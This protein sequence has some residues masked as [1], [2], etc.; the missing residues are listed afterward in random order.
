[1]A[2]WN[3]V[4][5]RWSPGAAAPLGDRSLPDRPERAAARAV[6][7]AT[8]SHRAAPYPWR[9]RLGA[10]VA[11]FLGLVLLAWLLPTVI[12]RTPLMGWILGR[13]VRV[14]GTASLEAA[15]LGW[16]SPV[17]LKGL[18][19]HD[20][21]GQAVLRVDRI[22]T[23]KSLLTLLRNDGD[24]GVIRV[25][26]P[27]LDV[28]FREGETNVEEVFAPY[29]E[30]PGDGPLEL[31]VSL[32]IEGLQV[33]LREAASDRRWGLEDGAVRIEL[34]GAESPLRMAAVAALTSGRRTGHLHAE[35]LV[36]Q[37]ATGTGSQ[38]RLA[39]LPGA[40]HGPA[41][42]GDS[43]Q[44][45]VTVRIEGLD[46]SLVEP[47]LRRLA[48]TAGENGP[49]LRELAG[50]AGGE[51]TCRWS[52]G[53]M[54]AL[55]FTGRV[56]A[57]QLTAQ[58]G[59]LGEDRLRLAAIEGR[60][61]AAFDGRSWQV[62]EAAFQSDLGRLDISGV[63]TLPGGSG[64]EALAALLEQP[65]SVEGEVDL[66]R[67]AAA[68]PR[69]LQ[70]R[71]GTDV[72]AGKVRLAVAGGPRTGE[73]FLWQGRLETTH[74]AAVRGGRPIVWEEPISMRFEARR[75]DDGWQIDEARCRADFLSVLAAGT[76]ESAA[77]EVEFDL[78]V[79][80]ERLAGFVDLDR[81]RL[82]G[83][84]RGAVQWQR[85]PSGSFRG[86]ADFSVSDLVLGWGTRTL[87]DEEQVALS[88]Q[89]GGWT[90]RRQWHVS[91]GSR[92]EARVGRDHL[93][94]ELAHP[95]A[96]V[97]ATGRW[98]LVVAATGSLASWQRR[99]EGWLPMEGVQ[100]AGVCR[101]DAEGTVS[102]AGV[103]LSRGR[104]RIDQLAVSAPGW[105]LAEPG[106]EIALRGWWDRSGG[107]VEVSEAE[108]TAAAIALRG[109]NLAWSGDAAEAVPSGQINYQADLEQLSRWLVTEEPLPV[110]L[111]GRLSGTGSL[112]PQPAG[113]RGVALAT[114]H[115]LRLTAAAGG[116]A[117]HE[118]QV[119]LA[120]RGTYQAAERTLVLEQATLTGAAL[121]ADAGGTATAGSDHEV[122]RLDLAGSLQYDLE[123]FGPLLRSYLG[124]GVQVAGAG[125]RP[126]TFRGPLDPL[127]A[128]A[129]AGIVWQR[130]HLYGVQ[131]GSGELSA[132]LAGGVLRL[133]PLDVEVSE[134]RLK[135]APE[136]RLA[137]GPTALV[138]APGPLLEQVRVN[139]RMCAHFLQYV[140]PVLA[141]VTAAE[142]RFSV[143]LDEC[144][145]PLAAPAEA[146]VGGRL[147]VHQI[148]VAA[149][150]LLYELA[151]LLGVE[152]RARLASN[153]VV[154]F[155]MVDRRV[156]HEAVALDLGGLTVQTQ[157]SVG[158]DG[159]LSLLAEVPVPPQWLNEPQIRAAVGS[160]TLRVPIGG[161]LER[162][163]LDRRMLDQ[164]SQQMVRE[165]T[166]NVIE[167]NLN[168]QL[169]RLWRQ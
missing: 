5:P 60:L 134:G 62:A 91:A 165:T 71:E 136:I 84:G 13:G 65:L 34:A 14:E 41:E 127:S 105:A 149:G 6:R 104:A 115:D 52:A 75:T 44:S 89:V 93:R 33:R 12:A 156:Y 27:E 74:L 61:D 159:T 50:T 123:R 8:P 131:V 108:L 17:K 7:P 137:G 28:V 57:E 22:E 83:K 143:T 19:I 110:K 167:E 144:H 129:D 87:A 106:V 154:R 69:L 2:W 40:P 133:R 124:E 9:R 152:A 125:S 88:A 64:A 102:A 68:V 56:A 114:I 161:T 58:G 119:R 99:L 142:G 146:R 24:L 35:A 81:G 11:V 158:L 3:R 164:L 53:P 148:D 163:Q 48:A 101:L 42:S 169:E 168:R 4:R 117:Y 77:A 23:E 155:R 111:S 112:D 79:L 109:E 92:A 51:V 37:G 30:A 66:A 39:S 162:P 153:S 126:W 128:T 26:R 67:L 15:S 21:D 80:A 121:S 147:D 97:G 151:L 135:A 118:P 78:G 138:L 95:G 32:L 73:E 139:P 85:S 54:A 25:E 90:D 150:P 130:A 100:L 31:A 98:P 82:A 122:A 107:R 46:L 63:L 49:I 45:R 47:L 120:V 18:A 36:H 116:A 72:R 43:G 103:E 140:A 10:A 132:E 38:N 70:I 96:E 86:T 160:Q 166:R 113:T 16:F 55:T 20:N 141:G 29:L 145:V 76:P 1:M 157:G 94:V 59:V